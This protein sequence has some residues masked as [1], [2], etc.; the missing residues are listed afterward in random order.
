MKIGNKLG[1]G[2][3]TAL[4]LATFFALLHASRYPYPWRGSIVVSL[5]FLALALYIAAG[6]KEPRWWFA[7]PVIFLC[8]ALFI[9]SR[10]V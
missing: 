7:I 4:L 6:I 5:E 9:M 10:G 1:I 2:A 3:V 8:V